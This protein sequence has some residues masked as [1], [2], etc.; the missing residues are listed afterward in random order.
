MYRRHRKLGVGLVFAAAAASAVTAGYAAHSTGIKPPPG[1]TKAMGSTP[2]HHAPKT[3]ALFVVRSVRGTLKPLGGRRYR[4]ALN[5]LD[6]LSVAFSDRPAR[7]TSLLATTL[8]LRQW[9]AAFAGSPP[10]AALVLPGGKARGDTFVFE[11]ATPTVDARHH[12]ASFPARLLTSPPA[13]FGYLR[14]RV[15]MA[16]P[17]SFGASSVFIDSSSSFNTSYCGAGINNTSPYSLFTPGADQAYP[18]FLLAGS[19]DTDINDDEEVLA[20]VWPTT[21]IDPGGDL[22]PSGSAGVSESSRFYI[23]C[24]QTTIYHSYPLNDDGSSQNGDVAIYVEY[25]YTG[26]NQYE[27][28]STGALDISCRL[29]QSGDTPSGWMLNWLKYSSVALAA[30]NADAVDAVRSAST[31]SVSVEA[32]I[33]TRGGSQYPKCQA[34]AAHAGCPTLLGE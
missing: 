28:A 29:V 17:R 19:G 30:L 32:T 26:A 3:S 34:S 2:S 31:G 4:L 11:L 20:D 16:P 1:F 23:G 24:A 5:G 8:F 22:E 14:S 9:K 7:R 10:N 25:D 18:D 6:R 12:S 33:S 27:C 13:R 15:D 21:N